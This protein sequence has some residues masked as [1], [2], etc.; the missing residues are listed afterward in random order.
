MQASAGLPFQ[1]QGVPQHMPS[2]F[3][4][5]GMAGGPTQQQ[6][7]ALSQHAQALANNQMNTLQRV[8]Q[9]QDHPNARP[10]NNLL[11]QSQQPPNGSASFTARAGQN[12]HSPGLGLPQGQGS[13]QQNLV[14]Q[15]NPSTPSAGLQS[16]APPSQAP[17]Q[18]GQQMLSLNSIAEAPLPHL[19]NIFNQLARSVTEGEK[20]LQ[21]LGEPDPQRRAKL[22]NQKQIMLRIREIITA[23]RGR[24]K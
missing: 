17:P 11:T 13:L 3:P 21:A 12:F 6:M 2:T 4:S 16:S 15:P 10:L 20:S 5:G 18:G 9:A 1:E 23:R 19:I 8:V 22:D 7:T 14:V 24:S